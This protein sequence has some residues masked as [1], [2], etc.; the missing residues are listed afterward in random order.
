MSDFPDRSQLI[1]RILM[2]KLLINLTACAFG[3]LLSST[4]IAADQTSQEKD[5]APAAA[6]PDTQAPAADSAS[7]PEAASEAY[8]AALK[9]CE[10]LS[11]AQKQT[12]EEKAK[13]EHGKM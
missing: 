4:G 1:E 7:K 6:Q 13:K 8:T 5:A 3:L 12:C 10:S 2:N 11:G 9:K